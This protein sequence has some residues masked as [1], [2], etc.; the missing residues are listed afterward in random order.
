[1]PLQITNIWIN[2]EF[3]CAFLFSGKRYPQSSFM[4]IYFIVNVNLQIPENV[5]AT[6]LVD[7]CQVPSMMDF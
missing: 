4:L 1:M 7:L 3:F 2:M 6:S 5:L